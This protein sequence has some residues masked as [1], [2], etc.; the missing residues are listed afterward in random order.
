MAVWRRTTIEEV[1]PASEEPATPG[2]AAADRLVD[3]CLLGGLLGGVDLEE[4]VEGLE[5]ERTRRLD[6]KANEHAAEIA[7]LEQRIGDWEARHE[8]L[9]AALELVRQQ[10]EQRRAELSA[11]NRRGTSLRRVRGT[12]LRAL[13]RRRYAYPVRLLQRRVEEQVVLGKELARALADGER[14][15]FELDR[16]HHGFQQERRKLNEKEFERRSQD[17]RHQRERVAEQLATMD[18]KLAALQQAGITHKSYGFLIWA[19]YLSFPAFGWFAGEAIRSALSNKASLLQ[20]LV[21]LLAHGVAA[22]TDAMGGIL[23]LVAVAFLPLAF[24]S[25][26]AAMLFLN[27]FL[28]SRFDRSWRRRKGGGSSGGAVVKQPQAT[29]RRSDYTQ[30]LA[31]LPILYAWWMVPLGLATLVA[32]AGRDEDL[33]NFAGLWAKP[34]E[35]VFYTFLGATIAVVVAG[36]VMLYCTLVVEPRLESRGPVTSRRRLLVENLEVVVLG[37]SAI[38]A[39]VIQAALGS[40]GATKLW[41]INSAPGVLLLLLLG[42]FLVAYGLMYKGLFHTRNAALDEL[43]RLDMEIG[44]YEGAPAV[45]LD[46]REAT[47]YRQRL[48]ALYE[49]IE[50]RWRR[51]EHFDRPRLTVRALWETFHDE[52]DGTPRVPYRSLDTL[53]EPDLVGEI[54]SAS[55]QS[56]QTEGEATAVREELHRL[57][58]EMSRQREQRETAEEQKLLTRHQLLE[59]RRRYAQE[60]FELGRAYRETITRCETAYQMGLRLREPKKP[61]LKIVGA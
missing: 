55:V 36:F 9:T 26:L 24:V 3:Q 52:R 35:S 6:D 49:E 54:D 40:A 34:G 60:T 13:A 27:D 43:R 57:E 11:L 10:A 12:L 16:E 25:V 47:E 53:I 39:V 31:K 21:T 32:F 17:L 28:I 8:E 50:Q 58:L 15:L 41:L 37:G 30:V 46:D 19:G 18:R 59:L 51:V 5:A 38:L 4:I 45:A 2:T 20:D 14:T 42:G 33:G 56:A 61:D 29:V 48:R 7:D 23:A 22:M 1:Q 44:R